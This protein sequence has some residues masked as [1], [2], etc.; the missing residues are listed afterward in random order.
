MS[1]ISCKKCG[2]S[3]VDHEVKEGRGLPPKG[4][5]NKTTKKI[6]WKGI[7]DVY[8]CN[9]CSENWKILRK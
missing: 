9:N 1:N 3:E 4:Y 2:S 8:T 7:W 6:S 5:V